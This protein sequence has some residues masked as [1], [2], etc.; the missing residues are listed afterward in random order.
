MQATP[1]D[2]VLRECR[3]VVYAILY[4]HHMVVLGVD[5][6]GRRCLWR[7]LQ[8]WREVLL[9]LLRGLGTQKVVDRTLVRVGCHTHHGRDQ[10]CEV[11]T[12]R[13]SIERVANHRI[14]VGEG[15]KGC[16]HM[17]SRRTAHCADFRRVDAPLFGIGTHNLHCALC[18]LQRSPLRLDKVSRI[19]QSVD[20]NKGVYTDR[21]EPL[22]E[23]EACDSV[24]EFRVA[25]RGEDH[26]CG[27]A[28]FAIRGEEGV[29]PWCIDLGDEFV[30][31]VVALFNASTIGHS[32]IVPQLDVLLCGEVQCGERTQYDQQSFHF[33]LFIFFV[34]S[35]LRS[36]HFV[37]AD[38]SLRH[39]GLP[40]SSLRTPHFVIA[41]SDPQS[42]QVRSAFLHYVLHCPLVTAGDCGSSPQ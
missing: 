31:F 29:D 39:C 41:D 13:D 37:I 10:N 11:G 22:G 14:V 32:G 21:V 40:T 6:K 8:L 26:Y 12:H 7:G 19:G 9:L 2:T 27:T 25:S 38:S 15:R 4:R 36:L 16:C 5:D 18:I 28:I 30:F 1:C 3:V 35:S 34:T 42:P 20:R 17:T 23:R 24:S 33:V